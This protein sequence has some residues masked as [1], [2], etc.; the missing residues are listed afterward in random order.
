MGPINHFRAVHCH[1]TF[2]PTVK[3]DIN[4]R[5]TFSIIYLAYAIFLKIGVDITSLILY[6]FRVTNSKYSHAFS[7]NFFAGGI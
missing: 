4:N 7:L 3:R 1:V 2:C 5:S 6:L